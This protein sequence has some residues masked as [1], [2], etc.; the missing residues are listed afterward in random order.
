MK[1][2]LIISSSPRKNSNSEQLAKAFY[3]G[4]K[5]AGNN[6]EFINLKD[7]NLG[8]CK[9]C[10]VCEKTGKCFQND[11]MNEIAEKLLKADVIA[12]VTPV[13]FYTMS[14]QLKVLIDR[15]VPYYTQV[16]AD[17]YLFCTA[18]DS[19]TKNLQL[20]LES[21]RGCTRDCFEECEEKGA[22]AVGGVNEAGAIEG[23]EELKTAFEM[24]Y[25]C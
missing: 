25:S 3:N 20:A 9:A 19:E 15:L 24:G 5:E 8:Y 1:N 21:I 4:A 2:V 11:G 14:A 10:Y 22:L 7:Y 16:R 6:V 12:F 17:I 18:W 13:Y 23:R